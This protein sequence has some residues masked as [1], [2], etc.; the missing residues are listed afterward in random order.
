MQAHDRRVA[1][2]ADIEI[3]GDERLDHRQRRGI[4]A[5]VDRQVVAG[6]A[7]ALLER[8]FVIMYCVTGELPAAQGWRPT[9]TLSGLCALRAH[10]GGQRIACLPRRQMKPRRA[11]PM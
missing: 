1:P 7:A 10:D 6:S 2:H 8:L 9:E 11:A 4:V 3:A 5:P